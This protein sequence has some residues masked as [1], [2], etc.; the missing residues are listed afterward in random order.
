MPDD[1][2]PPTPAAVSRAEHTV[3]AFCSILR[4]LSGGTMTPAILRDLIEEGLA[5]VSY[6]VPIGTSPDCDRPKLY[7]RDVSAPVAVLPADWLDRVHENPEA[8][9]IQAVGLISALVDCVNEKVDDDVDTRARC[10][11]VETVRALRANGAE[12]PV[13]DAE[14]IYPDGAR[15][16]LGWWYTRTTTAEIRL[17]RGA[18][19]RATSN[20]AGGGPTNGDF[21]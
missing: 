15:P 6:I 11:M 9:V 10:W 13:L 14:S 19:L 18:G 20:L 2:S 16:G 12:I 21:S 17:A 5:V 3:A 8:A 7:L 4:G 1:P